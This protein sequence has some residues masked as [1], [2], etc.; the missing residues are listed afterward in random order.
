M[1]TFVTTAPDVTVRIF[2]NHEALSHAAAEL[3]VELGKAAVA[4][5]GRF[6]VALSGGSTPRRFYELLGSSAYRDRVDWHQVHVFW[7]DERC[8]PPDHR[9]SNFKLIHDTLLSAV[10]L[11]EINIHRIR[12]EEGPEDAARIYEQD[13]KKY[14][15]PDR[16]AFNLVALGVGEDGHTASIFPNSEA[17]HETNRIVIPIFRDKPHIPRVTLALTM[18]NLAAHVLV[19]ASGRSKSA[20]VREILAGENPRHYP[21]GLVR[22]VNGD[23]TWFVDREAATYINKNIIHKY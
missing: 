6:A 19:L 5:Q 1:E 10:P 2:E 22:P 16:R 4:S 23:L 15:S 21:A 9:E 8:V 12:G 20:I 14:F 18:I 13:I 11:P 3:F 7:A 17:S